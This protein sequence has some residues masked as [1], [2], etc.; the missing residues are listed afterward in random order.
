MRR[1]AH[2]P[3]HLLRDVHWQADRAALVGERARDGLADPP[4]RV[5]RELVAHAVVELLHRTDQPEVAL[6]DQV[7]QRH[8]GLRVVARDRHHQPQ[9]ALDQLALRGLVALVLP[10][11][12]LALL[13]GREQPAVADLADVELQRILGRLG[14]LRSRPRPP[15]PPLPPRCRAA[16]GARDGAARRA[17][18]RDRAGAG[19]PYLCRIGAATRALEARGCPN[20][21]SLSLQ[22]L[23]EDFGRIPTFVR[24]LSQTDCGATARPLPCV[25]KD[26]RGLDG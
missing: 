17:R 12:E 21:G 20:E 3:A 15:R 11:G 4:R 22:R 5:R 24:R 7:E 10:A 26:Q 19:L 16:A 13:G 8:A 9:V 23:S 2:Q 18:T 14:R 25:S 1:C 6:L